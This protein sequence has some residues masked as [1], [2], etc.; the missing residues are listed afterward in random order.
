MRNFRVFE[1][2][3]SRPSDESNC[4]STQREVEVLIWWNQIPKWWD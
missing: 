2:N 1:I 3:D 4:G